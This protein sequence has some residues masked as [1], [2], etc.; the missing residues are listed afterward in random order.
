MNSAA[1]N[2]AQACLNNEVSVSNT[3]AAPCDQ[4]EKA[5]GATF[6]YHLFNTV[7]K[8]NTRSAQAQVEGCLER[9]TR[10]QNGDGT[11]GRTHSD[12]H[13]LLVLDGLHRQGKL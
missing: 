7:S 4:S 6:F 11:W 3:S 10:A 8:S 5:R 12:L 2:H 13:S 1:P 9:I